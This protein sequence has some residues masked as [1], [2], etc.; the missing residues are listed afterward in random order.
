MVSAVDGQIEIKEDLHIK[1]DKNTDLANKICK[2]VNACLISDNN[3]ESLVLTQRIEAIKQSPNF[4]VQNLRDF[5]VSLDVSI[6]E[7]RKLANLIDKYADLDD[8]DP[9]MLNFLIVKGELAQKMGVGNCGEMS[10][11]GFALALAEEDGPDRIEIFEITNGDHAFLV[12]GRAF[13]SDP[14]DPSTWGE[15]AIIC[16]PWA[17][18]VYPACEFYAKMR[19]YGGREVDE[20]TLEFV[21]NFVPLNFYHRLLSRAEFSRTQFSAA[22]LD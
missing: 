1:A 22:A 17:N 15:S 5:F 18:A 16:D 21:T 2:F 11:L 7:L 12:I 13:G 14:N 8:S 3:S 9:A 10:F 6:M 19:D 4:V 20:E